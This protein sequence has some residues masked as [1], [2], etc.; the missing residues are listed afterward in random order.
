LRLLLKRRDENKTGLEEKALFNVRELV[1]PFLER[2]KKPVGF[3][4]SPT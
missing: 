4:N 2:L 1:V 3:Q